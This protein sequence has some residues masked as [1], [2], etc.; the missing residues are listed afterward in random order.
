MKK[1]VFISMLF[2]F[3]I[4]NSAST[5]AEENPSQQDF[6]IDKQ[7]NVPDVEIRPDTYVLDYKSDD[8]N[9]DGIK[10]GVILIG[11]REGGLINTYV[12]N[13]NI[14]VKDG[15]TSAYKKFMPGQIDSGYEPKLYLGDF[16]RDKIPD[17][18]TTIAT[19]G[20]GGTSMYSITAFRDNKITYLFNQVEFSQGLKFDI[21][22]KDKFKV[23]V[24]N[25]ETGKRFKLDV[26]DRKT[27][28]VELKVYNDNG[29]L[30]NLVTGAANPIS[31]LQ[32]V[33]KDTDGSLELYSVQRLTGIANADTIGYA[34]ATW[35]Y[36]ENKFV[37]KKLDVS[38]EI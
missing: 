21:Q 8:V 3:F 18:F 12:K 28:Y 34:A 31:L 23:D 27:D 33:N 24:T 11:T 5:K 6:Q 16:N 4:L 2:S 14:V 20:S 22:F 29:K 15:K 37:L 26:S 19:G 38:T 35:R 10:D 7:F 9:G 36:E 17:I 13:I 1:Y 30:L 25:K 32:P